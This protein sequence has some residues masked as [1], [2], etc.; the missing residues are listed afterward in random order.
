[1]SQLLLVQCDRGRAAVCCE[2]GSVTEIVPAVYVTFDSGLPTA[3]LCLSSP[4]SS[5][6]STLHPTYSSSHKMDGGGTIPIAFCEHL[7]LSSVGI[8]PQSISFQVGLRVVVQHMLCEKVV[9]T[10]VRVGKTQPRHSLLNLTTL[11][12]YEK[13]LASRTRSSSS[14]WQM[15]IMSCGG[16]SPPTRPLCTRSKRSSR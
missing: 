2:P 4:P 1:M 7:Q 12:V 9:L 6:T 16:P 3:T 5:P 13:K 10:V 8:Q 14:T 15:P 11:S